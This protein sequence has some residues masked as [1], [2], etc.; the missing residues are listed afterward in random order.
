MTEER[1]L[2]GWKDIAA[3]LT[4]LYRTRV[5][6]NS[7]QELLERTKIPTLESYLPNVAIYPSSLR[8][9]L[10]KTVK[11]RDPQ[12]QTGTIYFIQAGLVAIKIGWTTNLQN[13]MNGLNTA[14]P[15][16]LKLLGT[17]TNKTVQDEQKLH[18]KFGKYRLKGEWFQIC[19]PILYFIKQKCESKAGNQ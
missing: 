19:S 8:E 4:E 12:T 14:V 2:V 1:P 18:D 10:S 3:Y 6:E 17:L 15:L 5:S 11:V 7:A 13:R 9:T 16:D